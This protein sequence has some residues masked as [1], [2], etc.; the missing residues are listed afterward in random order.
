MST[1]A[2]H[3]PPIA[4]PAW[5]FEF[6]VISV[7][8]PRYS[9]GVE[10]AW[11]PQS[12]WSV[13]TPRPDAALMVL[14]LVS[15]DDDCCVSWRRTTAR[16]SERMTVGGTVLPG[17]TAD[18]DWATRGAHGK[19]FRLQCSARKTSSSGSSPPRTDSPWAWQKQGIWES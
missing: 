12:A 19:R 6:A 14:T 8:T 7:S 17:G 13:P 11:S 9:W 5:R 10:S 15:T 3:L 16:D 18:L 2:E 4:S 1:F